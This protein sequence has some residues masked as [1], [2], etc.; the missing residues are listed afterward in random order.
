[1]RTSSSCAATWPANKPP[2]VSIESSRATSE[3]HNSCPNAARYSSVGSGPPADRF[4]TGQRPHALLAALL[5]AGLVT[6]CAAA[7]WPADSPL[8][9]TFNRAGLDHGWRSLY[10]ACLI[11]AFVCYLVGLLLLSRWTLRLRLVAAFAVAIQLIP[12]GAPLLL[13]TDAWSYWDYGRIAAI[14]GGNPYRDPPDSFPADPSYPFAGHAWRDTTSVYG[15]LFTLASEPI[16]RA[17]GASADAAAWTYKA[18]AALAVLVA[19]ALAAFLARRK[20][21]AL[22]FVGWNP[23]LALNFAGGGHNDSWVAAAVLAALALAAS[24]RR[25]LAAVAWAVAIFIKWVPLLLLP[26][27]AVENRAGKRR[28]DATTFAAAALVIVGVA[29]WRYGF[30]WSNAFRPLA[31]AAGHGS[32]FALPHRLAGLGLSPPLALTIVGVAFA[33]TYIWLVRDAW[34]GHARL[35]LA[36]GLMLLAAPYVVSWYTVWAVPLAAAEDDPAAQI[37]ALGLCAYLLRQGITH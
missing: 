12:L 5:T 23:L 24:N 19:A 2:A 7:A 21:F 20:S 37:L 32:H 15:P 3:H 9:A 16:G 29:T 8:S 27:H 28:F 31:H 33:T 35:G 14:D 30:S 10:I 1:V 26:L 13:S 17:V 22:A 4:L 6:V 34:H 36:A 18:L 25:R 11:A